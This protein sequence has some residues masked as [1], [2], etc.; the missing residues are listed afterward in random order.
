MGGFNFLL[1]ASLFLLNFQQWAYTTNMKK[2]NDFKIIKHYPK[3]Y[4]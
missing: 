4:F 1:F 3:I 2:Y